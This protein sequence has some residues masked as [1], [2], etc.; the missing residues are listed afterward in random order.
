MLEMLSKI[1]IFHELLPC[2]LQ[3][4]LQDRLIEGAPEMMSVP[5]WHGMSKMLP[6]AAGEGC[7]TEL[8]I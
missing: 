5:M 8:R 7:T 1:L 4:L 3:G 2:S 6:L